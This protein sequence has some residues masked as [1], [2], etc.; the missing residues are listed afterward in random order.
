[1]RRNG[2]PGRGHSLGDSPEDRNRVPQSATRIRGLLQP[3]GR[4][5]R[6][7]SSS[8]EFIFQASILRK[9][10]FFDLVKQPTKMACVIFL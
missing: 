2:A 8:T 1:M 5:V 10:A 3:N 4:I 7:N 6:F 9:I